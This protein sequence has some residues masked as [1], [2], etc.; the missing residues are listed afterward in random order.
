MQG[1]GLTCGKSARSAFIRCEAPPGP[2]IAVPQRGESRINAASRA[3]LQSSTAVCRNA[4]SRTLEAGAAT[5]RVARR[6]RIPARRSVEAES[7][8]KLAAVLASESLADGINQ[9]PS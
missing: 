6:T 2:S 9:L 5:R 1:G 4:A 3:L 8:A 7:A